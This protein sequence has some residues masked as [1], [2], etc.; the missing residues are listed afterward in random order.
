M[1]IHSIERTLPERSL[2]VQIKGEKCKNCPKIW[3]SSL[4]ELVF[5]HISSPWLMNR[6]MLNTS[7]NSC[8]VKA[9]DALNIETLM[10]HFLLHNYVFTL[11]HHI[12]ST[13]ITLHTKLIMHLL[14][15]QRYY[16]ICLHPPFPAAWGEKHFCQTNTETMHGGDFSEQ[17]F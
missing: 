15:V 13:K 12:L 8:T 9:P 14:K 4:Y 1:F 10:T 5:P 11:K 17:R 2:L 6:Y 16:E 7:Y 3:F